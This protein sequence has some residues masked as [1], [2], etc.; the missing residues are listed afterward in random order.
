MDFLGIPAYDTITFN[1][2][3]YFYQAADFIDSALRANGNPRMTMWLRHSYMTCPS[4]CTRRLVFPLFSLTH[5][6]TQ[7]ESLRLFC[8]H[9]SIYR[10]YSFLAFSTFVCLCLFV[11]RLSLFPPFHPFLLWDDNNNQMFI[12][13]FASLWKGQVLVHCHAGISRSATIVAAYLMIKRHMTAQEAIRVIR[14]LW[15]W[16]SS[17]ISFDLTVASPSLARAISELIARFDRIPDS[18]S[19]CATW[20]SLCW[21][22]EDEP[23]YKIK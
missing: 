21:A 22:N 13:T 19:N 14:Y 20:T 7:R 6:L 15:Y 5:S 18:C 4:L 11:Q 3:R 10:P 8:L 16:S 9:A 17:A 23:E 12:W 2:S 1:L